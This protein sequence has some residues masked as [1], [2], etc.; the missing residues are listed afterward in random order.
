MRG[1]YPC[2]YPPRRWR[3]YPP[4]RRYQGSDRSAVRRGPATTV[5]VIP[6]PGRRSRP[7]FPGGWF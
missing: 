2:P 5:I 1:Y 3:R 7:R 6:N 4:R